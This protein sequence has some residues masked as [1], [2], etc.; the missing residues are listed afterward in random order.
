MRTEVLV[1]DAK[2]PA[3]VAIERAA[4]VLRTGRLAAF[5]TETVYGLGA[6]AADSE[7]VAKI[8]TAK[9][10]PS[11][12]PLIVHVPDADHARRYAADWPKAADQLARRFWPG[13]LTLVVPRGQ[14]I[15][16]AAVSG[17]PTVALR[18]PAHPVALALLRAANLPIA[19]PSANRSES[20]SPTRAEHVLR[21]LAGRI[22]L[23]LD[24]GSTTGGLES[25]VVDVTVDPPRILRPGLISPAALR[26][27]IGEVDVPT[28][29]VE[30]TSK[31][32]P[33]PGMT[34]RHYSPNAPLELVGSNA[35]QRV[36]ELVKGGVK[37][38]WLAVGGEEV[39]PEVV[40]IAL[41]SS[42]EDYS[43]H[44]YSALHALDESGVERIVATIPPDVEEWLAVRDRL[45]RA[46]GS[47]TVD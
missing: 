41:P 40:V 1:V 42:A 38:G 6:N 43:R 16:A 25:T 14:G 7:A 5:P 9:G 37:V 23:V 36:T 3:P 39:E 2:K 33:S 11:R 15:A 27:T 28:S 19:A 10:R 47:P 30:Q 46:A 21:T 8:Y 22:D 31:A 35:R 44:L 29:F 34:S 32:L 4:E 18:V 13:P 20:L 17:G 12:N 45:T 26:E 24:G